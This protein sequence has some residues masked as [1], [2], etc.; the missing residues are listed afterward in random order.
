MLS[1]LCAL[2]AY[3]LSWLMCSPGLCRSYIGH[4]EVSNACDRADV[5][6]LQ[7]E[8]ESMRVVVE[9]EKYD[10]KLNYELLIEKEK[11]KFTGLSLLFQRLHLLLRMLHLLL[12][13]L[14]VF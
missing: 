14:Y 6:K 1:G 12:R 13:M 11:A 2:L 5:K 3:V 7:E 10:L 9:R 8:M 4:P